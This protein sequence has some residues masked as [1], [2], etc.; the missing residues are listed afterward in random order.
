MIFLR[1]GPLEIFVFSQVL[2]GSTSQVVI[3]STPKSITTKNSDI[4]QKLSARIDHH[5]RSLHSRNN[6]VQ[7]HENRLLLL[8]LKGSFAVRTTCQVKTG[9]CRFKFFCREMVFDHTNELQCNSS[10]S[11]DKEMS[12]ACQI[13]FIRRL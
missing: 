8:V 3:D 2:L 6:S 4:S 12:R 5:F 9:V 1:P 10:T 13:K 11:L 7:C